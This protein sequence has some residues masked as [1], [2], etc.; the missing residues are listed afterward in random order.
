MSR[1]PLT[2]ATS[3]LADIAGAL[4]GDHPEQRLIA[5]AG[6][7][8]LAM[9]LA[10]N[11]L[12]G[13]SATNPIRVFSGLPPEEGIRLWIDDKLSRIRNGAA[14]DDE[15]PIF[16]LAGYLILFMVARRIEHEATTK[17]VS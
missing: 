10:K 1:A 4:E 17:V 2:R 12:Y 16:D 6:I 8:V 3:G 15:D 11:R 7:D 13:S 5:E 9:L 14:D